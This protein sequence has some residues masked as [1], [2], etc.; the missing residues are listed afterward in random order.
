MVSGDGVDGTNGAGA[1]AWVFEM[2]ALGRVVLTGQGQ[3]LGCSRYLSWRRDWS[4]VGHG[5]ALGAASHGLS[6]RVIASHRI[7]YYMALVTVVDW[8]WILSRCFVNWQYLDWMYTAIIAVTA[9]YY[10]Q[11]YKRFSF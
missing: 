3:E 11:K 7:G 2:A 8:T 4:L 10:R 5:M 9:E 1:G 6:C